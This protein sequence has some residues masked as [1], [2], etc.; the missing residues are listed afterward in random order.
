MK[1]HAIINRFMADGDPTPGAS[2]TGVA[3]LGYVHHA[4]LW[5]EGEAVDAEI[6]NPSEWG[7]GKYPVN[8]EGL[9]SRVDRVVEG[10]AENDIGPTMDTP[11]CLEME[12]GPSVYDLRAIEDVA[13]SPIPQVM[14]VGKAAGALGSVDCV[15]GQGWR[16]PGSLVNDLAAYT[17][18][19][20]PDR[21]AVPLYGG[22]SLN[23]ASE[24]QQPIERA[25]RLADAITFKTVR[26]ALFISPYDD[27]RKGNM[28]LQEWRMVC[29]SMRVVCEH[30]D[31]DV[32]MWWDGGRDRPDY[33]EAAEPHVA[34][35][36][37]VFAGFEGVVR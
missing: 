3:Q 29:Q 25:N 31:A 18:Y 28:D 22:W 24:R 36:R 16:T 13:K 6:E 37:E 10:I 14:H 27:G 19:G 34:V 7:K 21:L 35:F 2:V 11:I 23:W 5:Q 9:S 12:I 33:A 32:V 26:L 30:F 17:L 15:Y 20:C 8:W 4:H 1:A